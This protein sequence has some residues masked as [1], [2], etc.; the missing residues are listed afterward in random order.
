MEAVAVEAMGSQAIQADDPN[1]SENGE[2]PAREVRSFFV[3]VEETAVA[4][5]PHFDDAQFAALSVL[6]CLASMSISLQHRICT[7]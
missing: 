4:I 3:S 7:Y 5:L 6:P 1:A 2:S